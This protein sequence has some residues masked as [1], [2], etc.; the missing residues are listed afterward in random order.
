VSQSI[1]DSKA[2]GVFQYSLKVDKP[3]VRT[4]NHQIDTIQE[5]W[6]EKVWQYFNKNGKIVVQPDSANQL[7]ILF[8][9]LPRVR[10]TTNIWIKHNFKKLGW[11]GVAV[12]IDSI[13]KFYIIESDTANQEHVLDTFTLTK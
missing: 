13:G 3:I 2:N 1:A 8:N 12:G 6:V 4:G 10:D 11:N 5:A 7:A 9:K